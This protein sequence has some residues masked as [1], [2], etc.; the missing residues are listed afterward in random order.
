MK[1]L[2]MTIDATQRKS[3]INREL[4]GHFIEHTGRIVYD[5]LFV[6]RESEIP[7]VNGVR[8]DVIEALR[9]IDAPMLHWPG[10]WEAESYRWRNG[11]D[12]DGRR[13]RSIN[14]GT[15]TVD[16]NGFG[17]HE[18][19]DLCEQ[20]GA[21]PYLVTNVGSGSAAEAGEWLEYITY[22]GD[23]DTAELR[24]RNGRDEPWSLKYLCAGNEWYAYM[25]AASFASEY[26]RHLVFTR[27][28]G[29]ERMN[30]ILRG[31]HHFDYAITTELVSLVQPGSFHA[32]TLYHVIL[33]VRGGEPGMG[34]SEQFSDDEY[35]ATL[36][37]ALDLDES[38]TRHIEI[39]RAREGNENVRLAIDEWGTWHQQ[40]G[41]E[42][43]FMQITMRD[44]LVQ[45]TVLNIFNQRA[46]L[47]LLATLCM[48]I[49]A[50]SALLHTSGSQL[51]RTPAYYV[52]KMYKGHQ[53]ATLV[54]STL[55]NDTVELGSESLPAI[56]HSVSVK[57]DRLLI[58]LVN[59]SLD[60]DYLIDCDLGTDEYALVDAEILHSDD[61][62]TRN[63]YDQPDLVVAQ[64][65]SGVRQEGGAL[66]VELPR[67]SVVAV[68]LRARS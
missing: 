57:D 30:R 37:N 67:C 46:D 53:G 10:G 23:S 41:D 4:Y 21:E 26:Q 50:L 42:K 17:T 51:L 49:N 22:S 25:P 39:I 45:A 20:L 34:H 28:Y 68:R 64:P 24:R 61:V 18:F 43:W 19:F 65:F 12:Q 33:S 6:G 38:I 66:Q 47:L 27:N 36:A 62:R 56:S 8:T 2:R 58:T 14:A 1:T 11:I 5:G 31:A 29:P 63:H 40:D 60:R 35:Y 48:P 3:H 54:G 16:D 9:E 13:A 44:A 52:H 7:N 32:M 59:C 15:G 55:E